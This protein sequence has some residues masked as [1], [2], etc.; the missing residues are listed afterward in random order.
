MKFNRMRPSVAWVF[1]GQA[2][3]A[4]PHSWDCSRWSFDDFPVP[5]FVGPHTLDADLLAQR[6][7]VT[8]NGA[9]GFVKQTSQVFG[10]PSGLLRQERQDLITYTDIYW[11]IRHCMRRHINVFVKR[12]GDGIEHEVNKRAAIHLRARV[13]VLQGLVIK[14]LVVVHQRLHWHP[15][16]Q[17]VPLGKNQRLPQ[18]PDAAIAVAKRVDVFQPVV[19]GRTR[20][21]RMRFAGLP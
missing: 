11:G 9:G 4:W 1:G 15:G 13:G 10:G 21:E 8:L 2:L 18:P 20:D 6:L 14:R 12:I 16:K 17:R 3:L 19:N 7:E 5:G